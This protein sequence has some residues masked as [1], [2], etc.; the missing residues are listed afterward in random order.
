M[1]EKL[2]PAVQQSGE[3]GETV[4]TEL[5]P[6]EVILHVN[7]NVKKQT[8]FLPQRKNVKKNMMKVYIP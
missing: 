8:D 5:D 6:N 2:K 3:S 4:E 7:S 1:N